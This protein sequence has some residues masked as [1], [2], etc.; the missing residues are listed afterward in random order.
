M[1]LNL[2]LDQST[3]KELRTFILFLHEHLEAFGSYPEQTSLNEQQL[4][5]LFEFP[6]TINEALK[7]EHLPEYF[8]HPS[9]H[10]PALTPI[11]TRP[12]GRGRSSRTENDLEVLQKAAIRLVVDVY[13]KRSLKA[14][15]Q[16]IGLTTIIWNQWLKE[17]TFQSVLK[18]EIDKH[19]GGL[20]TDAKLSLARLVIDG[21]LQAIKYY[22]EFTG[23][24]R[25]G[26]EN[27]TVLNLSKVLA[28]M[29]EILVKYV[30]PEK[31]ESLA[32][33]LEASVFGNAIEVKAQ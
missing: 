9:L 24:Y 19:F 28:K 10:E 15:L 5:L 1:A 8:T 12:V 22:H 16:S 29:M 25:P 18:R 20:E 27:E 13:D 11:K 21:D 17:R 31:L 6:Y 30:E 14:K 32:D 23:I 33:E 2:T 7:A 26:L 3:P 4:Q